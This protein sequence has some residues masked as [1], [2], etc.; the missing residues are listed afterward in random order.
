MSGKQQE[1]LMQASD[2]CEPD[3]AKRVPVVHELGTP[4]T[5][6]EVAELLGCSPWTVRQ[7]YLR[8][9]LPHLQASA[10]GKLIFFRKQIIA[11]VEKQQRQKGGTL[12]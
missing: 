6:D 7:R 11:W 1:A 9:G 5:I 8:Q 12:R 4:L 3:F 2:G 10:H